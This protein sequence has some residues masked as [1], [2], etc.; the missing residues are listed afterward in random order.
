M[1]VTIRDVAKQADVSISTVSRVLNDTCPV[2]SEKRVR[3]E[4]AVAELGY[5]PNPAARSLLTRETGGIGIILPF[6]SE[7][8]SSGRH[9]ARVC[10]YSFC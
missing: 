9:S 1:G 10:Q 6:V 5:T 3:V 2:H 7:R 4:R 8:F